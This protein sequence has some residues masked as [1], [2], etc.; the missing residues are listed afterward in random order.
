MFGNIA[1]ER[2]REP[3]VLYENDPSSLIS[4]Y[5]IPPRLT[6]EGFAK[7][8]PGFTRERTRE[9]RPRPTPVQDQ[10]KADITGGGDLH[11]KPLYNISA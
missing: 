10:D 9:S 2:S 7:A 11:S 1:P 4:L 5:K 6:R 3:G 8:P